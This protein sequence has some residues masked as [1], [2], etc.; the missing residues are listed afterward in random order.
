M[1]LLFSLLIL[2]FTYHAQSQKIALSD[3][4]SNSDKPIAN[5]ALHS[6]S[7]SSSFAICIFKEVKLHRHLHHTEQIYVVSGEALMQLGESQFAIKKGDVILIRKGMPHKVTVTSAE[8]LK[9][10]SVQAPYFDGTDREWL[11]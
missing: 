5:S 11:E 6:D 9:V 2:L 3:C 7:L 1:K 8:P 10:L 4:Q